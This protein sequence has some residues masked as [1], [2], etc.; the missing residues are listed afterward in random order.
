MAFTVTNTPS[1]FGNK[2][3]RMLKITADAATQTVQ[4]GLGVIE[5]LDVFRSSMASAGNKIAVNLTASGVAAAGSLGITGCTSGDELY[6]TV[7]GR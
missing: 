4:T 6:V 5:H 2:Q 1:V 3:V 7:Y